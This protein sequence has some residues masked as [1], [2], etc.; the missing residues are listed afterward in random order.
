DLRG[1]VRMNCPTLWRQN[2]SSSP[3]GATIIERNLLVKENLA[4]QASLQAD[5][6]VAAIAT[7][8]LPA[9]RLRIAACLDDLEHP[10]EYPPAL[11][12]IRVRVFHLY[13][14]VLRSHVAEVAAS[15]LHVERLR[16]QK[17]VQHGLHL[18][19][20]IDLALVLREL[21]V[22]GRHRPVGQR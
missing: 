10:R 19:I 16:D 15:H 1:F 18:Q 12:A 8:G 3:A 14:L 9:R 13:H 5:I 21:V 20:V 6:S 22:E 4:P 7:A 11:L 17:A 2:A